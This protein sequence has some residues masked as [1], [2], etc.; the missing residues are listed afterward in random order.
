MT[1]QHSDKVDEGQRAMDTI[2][3]WK[4][5]PGIKLK[6]GQCLRNY[7][8]FREGKN[9]VIPIFSRGYNS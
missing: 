2:R 4:T 8:S 1:E 7:I 5:N 6:F 3:Q 9:N